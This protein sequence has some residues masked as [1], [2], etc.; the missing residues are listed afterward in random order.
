V[1]RTWFI[2]AK[3]AVYKPSGAQSKESYNTYTLASKNIYIEQQEKQ[4]KEN[5]VIRKSTQ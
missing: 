4:Q 2:A 5:N 1:D 3:W